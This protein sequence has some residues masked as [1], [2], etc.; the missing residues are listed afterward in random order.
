MY[1]L[2]EPHKDRGRGRTHHIP[3]QRL[4][5]TER[6]AESVGVWVNNNGADRVRSDTWRMM[7]AFCSRPA[8][9]TIATIAVI[10]VI[11]LRS[12]GTHRPTYST[13][14]RR[15][16]ERCPSPGSCMPEPEPRTL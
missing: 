15:A 11:G 13:S 5:L 3:P 8:I 9:L 2:E 16:L 6:P 1:P 4:T 14:V 10:A 7:K 12:V